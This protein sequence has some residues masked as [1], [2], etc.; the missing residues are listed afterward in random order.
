[1]VTQAEIDK[2][3]EWCKAKKAELNRIYI[4]ELNPFQEEIFWARNKIKIEIDRP[5]TIADKNSIVYDYTTNQ[6]WEYSNMNWKQ[7]RPD[8]F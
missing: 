4:I 5:T 1:M 8:Q 2:I 7:I 3:I 6:L